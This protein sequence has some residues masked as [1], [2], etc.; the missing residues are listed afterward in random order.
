MEIVCKFFSNL[1]YFD[2]LD[3]VLDKA[4]INFDSAVAIEEK[5]LLNNG[6]RPSLFLHNNYA[7][8]HHKKGE[9]RKSA[10]HLEKIESQLG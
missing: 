7:M 5:C 4:R 1:A 10:S 3:G 2:L 8:Y 9:W 6:Y